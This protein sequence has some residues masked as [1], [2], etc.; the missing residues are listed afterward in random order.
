MIAN[1]WWRI[2]C[3]VV[4]AGSVVSCG[5]DDPAGS[6][7][8]TESGET[9]D[10][11][12][13]A[14]SDANSADLARFLPEVFDGWSLA[15]AEFYCDLFADSR[16]ESHQQ[17][18]NDGMRSPITE[19]NLE[20]YSSFMND[21]C[22]GLS[23][24]AADSA[25]PSVEIPDSVNFDGEVIDGELCFTLDTGDS[26]TVDSRCWEDSDQ[27]F[28]N[29]WQ[30]ANGFV[31]ETDAGSHDALLLV[32]PSGNEVL[33]IEQSGFDVAWKQNG[34]A[35]VV[36]TPTNEPLLLRF[37]SSGRTLSCRMDTVVG[38]CNVVPD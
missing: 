7:A 24:R 28:V 3:G 14:Q 11:T 18:V 19:V 4:V 25:P 20:D 10:S 8:S 22:P 12:I 15:E 21:Y 5:S 16:I 34:H 38:L 30:I 6:E 37:N 17:F 35:V 27:P 23:A 36:A 9:A 32:S 1:M 26:A 31:I 29:D 33:S 2:V 13:S